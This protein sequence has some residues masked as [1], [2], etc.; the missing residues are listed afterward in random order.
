MTAL[1]IRIRTDDGGTRT[2]VDRHDRDRHQRH[3]GAGTRRTAAGAWG[4]ARATTRCEDR[5]HTP[6]PIHPPNSARLHPPCPPA[7]HSRGRRGVRARVRRSGKSRRSS[8][9]G[10]SGA[11]GGGASTATVAGAALAG[12]SSGSRSPSGWG[13]GSH[14]FHGGTR[15]GSSSS[16]GAHVARHEQLYRLRAGRERHRGGEGRAALDPRFPRRVRP[17]HHRL[18]N[19]VKVVTR[20]TGNVVTDSR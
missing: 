12:T 9:P 2:C 5:K 7:S 13:S 4:A 15:P 6:P 1:T 16:G 11:P 20:S 17:R 19:P 18:R 8:S 3:L 14:S 10:S